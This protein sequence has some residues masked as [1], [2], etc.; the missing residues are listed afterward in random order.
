MRDKDCWTSNNNNFYIDLAAY[1]NQ[2]NIFKKMNW[3]QYLNKRHTK[4]DRINFSLN[5]WNN[6]YNC[7]SG[8]K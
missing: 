7:E 2:P 5:L 3:E 1:C 4:P 8:N 6:N